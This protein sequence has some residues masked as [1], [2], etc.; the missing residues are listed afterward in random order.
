MTKNKN[1]SRG[2]TDPY[3]ELES[4]YVAQISLTWEALNWNHA[5]F[6]RVNANREMEGFCCP[7]RIAQQFQQFEVLLQRFIENEPYQR[8]Q[9]PEVY[10]RVRISCPKLL[11][12]PEFKGTISSKCYSTATVPFFHNKLC[13]I[14]TLFGAVRLNCLIKRFRGWWRQGRNDFIYW[15]FKDIGRCD[16][17]L[18]EFSQGR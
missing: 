18:H 6:R 12:V 1:S 7:A 3:L 15:I 14:F 4:A 16:P 2:G 5:N 8:G 9:R 10:A 13:L 11:Q 17:D